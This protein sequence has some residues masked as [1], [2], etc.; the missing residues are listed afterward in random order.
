MIYRGKIFN[1]QSSTNCDIFGD[2]GLV[3]EKGKIIDIG[4]YEK[5]KKKYKNIETKN[6]K[7]I[8]FPAFTDIHLHW[9]QNRVKGTFSGTELLPWLK[10]YIWPE[11]SKFKDKKYTDKMLAKFYKELTENGTRN[12]IIYSSVHKYALEKAISEGKKYGNFII[13]NV[14]MDQNSPDYLQMKTSDEIKLVEYLAKKYKEKYAVTP[15]FAPT[16]TMELMKK[17]AA[18]AKKH[19]SFIQ[20][21]LSENK[22]EI[23]WVREL[24]PEQKTYTEVYLKAGL[25]GKKTILG[26]A[27]HLEEKEFEILKKTGT[28]IAHCPT[29]NIALLS[30]RMPVEKFMK[31]KIPFALATDI[32]A[33]PKLSMLDVMSTYMDIH[34]KARDKQKKSGI[35]KGELEIPEI[36]FVD[37]L[38][39]ATLAGAEI[40]G[41]SKEHGNLNKGKKAEFV[42]IDF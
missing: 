12:G 16:C 9:V 35:K 15:R 30:G 18:I 39:R 20:T 32:G 22:G 13:G 37:A 29:S 11:E 28:N 10:K 7:G 42:V 24:F 21:H 27:I 34:N 17:T 26:H 19:G 41:I 1:P 40:M 14:L 25:L 31:Y 3:V 4:E 5:L 8:I 33:G 36:T 6:T 23:A 2:G 38:Y